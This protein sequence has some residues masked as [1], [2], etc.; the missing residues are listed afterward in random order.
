MRFRFLPA[1]EEEAM[2]YMF[3]V[4]APGLFLFIIVWPL[5]RLLAKTKRNTGLMHGN[6]SGGPQAG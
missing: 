5:L 2:S 1:R 4:G 3:G 6:P